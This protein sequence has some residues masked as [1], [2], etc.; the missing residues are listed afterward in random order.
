[1]GMGGNLYR[2]PKKDSAELR[3]RQAAQVRDQNRMH[4][5]D[6]LMTYK[7]MSKKM[8][9]GGKTAPKKNIGSWKKPF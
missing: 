5:Q 7:N 2:N 1:M 4:E 3:E 6:Q 9:T 8:G